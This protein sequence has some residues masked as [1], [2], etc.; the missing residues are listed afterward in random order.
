MLRYVPFPPFFISL[1][2]SVISSD[3]SIVSPA[4]TFISGVDLRLRLYI[5]ARMI[6]WFPA[7]VSC[8]SVIGRLCHLVRK[9]PSSLRQPPSSPVS[10][11][12]SVCVLRQLHFSN[13]L[14][15]CCQARRVLKNH[16][17]FYFFPLSFAFCFSHNMLLCFYFFPSPKCGK[18]QM[19]VK[20]LKYKFTWKIWYCKI[21]ILYVWWC[22]SMYA[23][24][25]SVA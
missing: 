20:N 14:S 21:W 16:F 13:T 18:C 3:T 5:P 15:R 25:F 4:T 11:S 1:L 7:I 19:T 17:A 12:V 9:P 6:Y 10:T 24:A 2:V 8:F 23:G 22:V